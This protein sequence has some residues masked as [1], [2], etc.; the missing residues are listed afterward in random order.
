[1]RTDDL[2][3]TVLNNNHKALKQELS[4]VIA[5]SESVIWQKNKDL[6]TEVN[7]LKN[8]VNVLEDTLERERNEDKLV[9]DYGVSMEELTNLLSTARQDMEDMRYYYTNMIEEFVVEMEKKTGDRK[10]AETYVE[11]LWYKH[12]MK[13][14]EKL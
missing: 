14:G 9:T 13:K 10:L 2:V 8:K 12:A 7:K 3:M 11:N 5:Q 4:E 1:M 6:R